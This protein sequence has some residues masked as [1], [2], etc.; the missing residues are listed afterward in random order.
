M[1]IKTGP[2][3]YDLYMRVDT[4]TRGHHQWFY[5]KVQHDIHF[6]NK[7]VTFNIVNFTKK[8]SLYNQG[9]RVAISESNNDYKWV[10][11]GENIQ[12]KSSKIVKKIS[13]DGSLASY[14]NSLSFQFEFKNPSG[15]I[16]FAYCFPYTFSCLYK[17]LVSQPRLDYYS[18]TNFCK[19][20]SGLD[21]PLLTITS[22]LG[23]DREY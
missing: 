2:L 5:F 15:A 8:E 23:F 17:F 16:Y 7:R 4:N 9:M 10:K 18:H 11:G 20:L 3:E 14:Y 19:S 22:R 1:V 12:Y 13:Y 6:L 21:V